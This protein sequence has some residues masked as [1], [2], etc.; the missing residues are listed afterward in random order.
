[1]REDVREARQAGDDTEDTA[2]GVT[3]INVNQST[4]S[5]DPVKDNRS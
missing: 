2:I 5:K 1:M 4:Q 3:V